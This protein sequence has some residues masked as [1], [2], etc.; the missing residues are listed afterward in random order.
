MITVDCSEAGALG[1]CEETIPTITDNCL[2]CPVE[3]YCSEEMASGGCID[4]LV[5]KYWAVDYCGN[6][7]DTIEQIIMI[8][9][10]TPPVFT[11]FP[12]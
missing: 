8:V 7:S 4:N 2:D 3:T 11:E 12:R 10:E 6:A 9:D 5:R 1:G